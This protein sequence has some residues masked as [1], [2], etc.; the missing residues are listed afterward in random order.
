M[1]GKQ[2]KI[3]RLVDGETL[4]MFEYQN[5]AISRA[6]FNKLILSA[7]TQVTGRERGHL[8]AFVEA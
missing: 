2:E 7:I 5:D 4:K 1:T 8:E 6:I 3:A